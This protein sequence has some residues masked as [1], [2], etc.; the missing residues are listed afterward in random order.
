MFNI[1]PLL[2]QSVDSLAA[3]GKR[4]TMLVGLPIVSSDN[5]ECPMFC[6]NLANIKP[7]VLDGRIV[8]WTHERVA[9]WWN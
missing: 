8:A 3:Q 6:I 2:Q 7:L 9:A 5:R 1:R 4:D